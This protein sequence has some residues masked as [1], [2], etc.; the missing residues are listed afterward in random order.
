[1][2]SRSTYF[3]IVFRPLCLA[4]LLLFSFISNIYAQDTITWPHHP[5]SFGPSVI[6]NLDQWNNAH[7]TTW[8]HSDTLNVYNPKPYISALK[9]V[10]NGEHSNISIS[11]AVDSFLDREATGKMY[12]DY[13]LKLTAEDSFFW[14]YNVSPDKRIYLD[15]SNLP[16]TILD[17]HHTTPPFIQYNDKVAPGG[18][19]ILFPVLV[20]GKQYDELIRMLSCGKISL[21][22][23]EMK[24]NGKTFISVDSMEIDGLECGGGPKLYQYRL[25]RRKKSSPFLLLSEYSFGMHLRTYLLA[26]YDFPGYDAPLPRVQY[27]TS[28]EELLVLPNTPDEVSVPA[29]NVYNYLL[30]H[31]TD[32]LQG[33]SVDVKLN[34]QPYVAIMLDDNMITVKRIAAHTRSSHTVVSEPI[35][36]YLD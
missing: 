33:Q 28:T 29:N 4:L 19:Q 34:M 12:F 17:K 16:Y 18:G 7:K 22:D 13:K 20:K 25:I 8:A 32:E 15:T 26:E 6:T 1:M 2:D 35:E 10:S 3:S 14:T 24:V 23:F 21:Y 11:F 36:A 27:N 5:E 9:K 31:G 30:A